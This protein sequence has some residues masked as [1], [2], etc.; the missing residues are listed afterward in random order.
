MPEE[1][2]AVVPKPDPAE[3][4]SRFMLRKSLESMDMAAA[5]KSAV[6]ERMF[7]D[8][9]RAQVGRQMDMAGRVVQ[10]HRLEGRKAVVLIGSGHLIFGLGVNRLVGAMSGQPSKSVVPVGVPKGRPSVTVTRSLA[11][12]IVG[13]PAEERPAYPSIGLAFKAAPDAARLMVASKPIDG[14]ARGHDFEESDIVLSVDGLTFSDADLLLIHLAKFP[15]GGEIRFRLLRAGAE[16]TV[17]L[18]LEDSTPP[19]TRI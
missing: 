1:V 7:E 4:D 13:V 12:Y 9:Y 18:K 15:W 8:L 19:P 14:A 3:E 17:V 2:K 6:L 11:D 16:R 10:A 5:L